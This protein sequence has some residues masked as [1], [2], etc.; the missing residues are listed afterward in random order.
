[1]FH[2]LDGDTKLVPVPCDSVP[3][4]GSVEVCCASVVLGYRVVRDVPSTMTVVVRLLPE[5][6]AGTPIVVL[7]LLLIRIVRILVWA[8]AAVEASAVE[9][10]MLSVVPSAIQHI[11]PNPSI[12][13]GLTV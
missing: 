4:R 1:M 3:S 6:V 9:L 8:V 5:V 12:V 7:E 2:P 13:Q 11:V 10:G